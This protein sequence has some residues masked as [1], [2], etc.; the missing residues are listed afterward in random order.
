MAVV[1]QRRRWSMIVVVVRVA[2]G[3]GHKSVTVLLP[4]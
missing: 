1:L 2:E 4:S 3:M